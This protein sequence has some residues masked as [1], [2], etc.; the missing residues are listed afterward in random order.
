M[1]RPLRLALEAALVGLVL[2]LAGWL[3]VHEL[4]RYLVADELR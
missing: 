1:S 4:G 2:L 3:R